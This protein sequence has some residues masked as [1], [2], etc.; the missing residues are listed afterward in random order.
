MPGMRSADCPRHLFVDAP[1]GS[2]MKKCPFCAESIQDEATKC[3]FCG[4]WLN[5]K[6]VVDKVTGAV[7]KITSAVAADI[8]KAECRDADPL[9]LPSAGESITGW[10]FTMAGA[11]LGFLV[12]FMVLGGIMGSKPQLTGSL[13]CVI[14]GVAAGGW[15]GHAL[16]KSIKKKLEA[17]DGYHRAESK[18]DKISEN[19]VTHA[20]SQNSQVMVGTCRKCGHTGF[21]YDQYRKEYTCQN[22]GDPGNA[23]FWY[24]LGDAYCKLKR[25]NDGIEAYRQAVRIDPRNADAWQG[26]GLAYSL[27]GNKTAALDAVGELRRL[28]PARADNLFNWVAPR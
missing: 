11:I 6:P 19:H 2:K 21:D 20:K 17:R 22:C 12:F 9:H 8:K 28:D 5:R 26:L 13:I 27:S 14:G 15:L 16:H 3:R 25:Y 18:D 4:E 1:G 23:M 10:L 7:S 24:G